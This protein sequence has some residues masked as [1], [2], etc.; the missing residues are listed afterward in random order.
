M[1]LSYWSQWK[2]TPT[3]SNPAPGLGILVGVRGRTYGLPTLPYKSN[4]KS[5]ST[6][7]KE[8]WYKESPKFR[9]LEASQ[10]ARSVYFGVVSPL[11]GCSDLSLPTE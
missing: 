6:I 4:R 7:Q 10:A 8:N 9:M 11:Y 3:P 5:A 2:E 1:T